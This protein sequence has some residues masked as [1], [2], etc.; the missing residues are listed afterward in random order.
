MKRGVPRGIGGLLLLL[1]M[2]FPSGALSASD[3][4]FSGD[5]PIPEYRKPKT[6]EERQ[7]KR[8]YN[9]API[10]EALEAV[11]RGD[12]G[13]AEPLLREALVH[14]PDDNRV[15]L[16]LI[17]VLE[18]L[19]KFDEGIALCDEVLADYP[20][21]L[22][23]WRSKGFMA[24]RGGRTEEA[25]A[26]L[27][28]LLEAA[29]P[30][31]PERREVR[32]NLAELHFKA[33]RF[34]R[35]EVYGKLWLEQ[36]DS[37]HARMLVAECAA[38]R[39][40]W[41]AAAGLLGDAPAL[42]ATDAER[43]DA[44][45]RLAYALHR[46]G[47]FPE[48][49]KAFLA[50]RDLL[51]E[52]GR[53]LEIQKQLG[54]N[55]M[56]LKEPAKAA[57]Y[58]K[59]FLAEA[60]DEDVATGRLD[61][62]VLS[63][64]WDEARGVADA[65][66]QDD[67]IGPSL[68]EHAL[69]TLMHA[70]R[71][72]GDHEARLAAARELCRLHPLPAY[73]LEG[74]LAAELLDRPGDAIELYAACLDLQ[75]EPT[76]ALSYHYLLKREG[77]PL[78]PSLLERIAAAPAAEAVVRHQAL[79]E[80]AQLRRAA[81]DD[82]G[83]FRIMGDLL[84]EQPA[85]R[86]FREY[87][88]QL[89]VQGHYELS[90]KI[91]AH[92]IELEQDPAVNFETCKRIADLYLVQRNAHEAAAW[93]N[94]GRTFGVPDI[95][96]DLAMAK[97]DYLQ[98]EYAAVVQRLLPLAG[99]RDDFHLYIGYSFYKLGM[100]GL[101][102]LHLNRVSGSQKLSPAERYNLFANRAYLNFDQGQYEAALDDVSDALAFRYT[103]EL[104]LVR[105]RTLGRLGLH[106]AVIDEGDLLREALAVEAI[107]ADESVRSSVCQLAG[108]SCLRLGRWEAAVSNLTL[109]IESGA[110]EL[111]AL[112]LRGLARFKQ[113]EFEEAERDFLDY[114]GILDE[115]ATEGSA[116]S[117][118]P[119][120]AA[121]PATF[122]GDL[123]MIEGDLEDHDLA[124]AALFASIET[125]P[126][127][128]ATLIEAGYQLMKANRNAEAKELFRRAI[129]VFNDTVPHLEGEE[130]RAYAETRR[131]MKVEYGKLDKVWGAQAY[132]SRTEFDENINTPLQ[133]IDGALPS[134]LG[135]Q[136]SYRPPRIGFRN[137]KLLNVYGRVLANFKPNSFDVDED[138]CQGGVGI[139]YKPLAGH[140]LHI[141]IERLFKIGDNAEDNWLWRNLGA[142]EW[143]EK[144][145]RDRDYWLYSK[146][147]TE[148]SFFLDDPERWIYY[149][150]GRLG[151][152]LPIARETLLTI[153]QGMAVARYES[154]DE[155]GLGTYAMLGLG[156][157]LRLFEREKTCV[158]QRW[159]V[160]ANAYY[161]FGWFEEQPETLDSQDFEG[162]IF[163]VSLV[164]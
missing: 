30:D 62:L 140:N 36:E 1:A 20:G 26:A 150:D 94:K 41:E 34:D 159:Y 39:G 114:Y 138:S 43:G 38:R 104:V 10:R 56:I 2:A 139:I 59:A 37:L 91:L 63:E 68:R 71:N 141:S 86:F 155:D 7:R 143:G 31:Y 61:A 40:D 13:S 116:A 49:E 27:E 78:D 100:P 57:E 107:P 75:F 82:A 93:L 164:K 76:P 5:L 85:A 44:Q 28:K 84:K 92:S 110:P 124:A 58:F 135:V 160:D 16:A 66:L 122:W 133:T 23:A 115:L 161:V 118:A 137:E 119:A 15:R 19:E 87:A 95:E 4:F 120:A 127:D 152:T 96:W 80:L 129:D 151:L 88:A 106:E 149:L 157:N 77:R 73:F 117:G 69:V 125:Y 70:G 158:T 130:A 105:L 81:G 111:E 162:F 50:A 123:G 22:D 55:A 98:E 145:L 64:R 128:A 21:Y 53:R 3:A 45:L 72:L 33:G 51:T 9:T 132:M 154:D 8:Y 25:V 14:D 42:A 163:G 11:G 90:A 24:A 156:V 126:Y 74:A 12:Y 97:A 17:T 99:D 46:T 121:P 65:L 102:L 108:L 153:P 35:A 146:A 67:R 6:W 131:D 47:R 112:Y 103:H 113:G 18:R 89:A 79:Y 54:F 60:F 144:P 148:L 142:W 83:Y 52:K 48:A 136:A 101:A 134:Q 29:P 109:C 147:Y 32:K